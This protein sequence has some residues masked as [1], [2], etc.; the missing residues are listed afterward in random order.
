MS[1]CGTVGSGFPSR[2]FSR[3]RGVTV[4]AGLSPTPSRLSVWIGARICLG[5]PPTCLATPCPI[6][7]YSYPSAS[8]RRSNKPESVRKF[9]TPF[10]IAYAS[11]PRLRGR[12]TLG[13][14]TFPRNPQTYG[15]QDSHLLCRY[16]SLQN[17]FPSVHG[18]LRYRFTPDENAPLPRHSEECHPRLR[19]RA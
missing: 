17:H 12:L 6:G 5:P 11:R 1:V 13:G 14:W 9:S 8:L 16:S 7:A 19:W 18:S 10:P 15:E 2:R 3:Q 4:D